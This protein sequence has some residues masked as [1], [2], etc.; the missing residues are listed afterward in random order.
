[1]RVITQGNILK[2]LCK[3]PDNAI[4]IMPFAI[5]LVTECNDKIPICYE[6]YMLT[7]WNG[8][9]MLMF[10]KDDYFLKKEVDHA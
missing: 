7:V 5:H 3:N 4:L 8:S 6:E 9:S 1:M 2:A 10:T